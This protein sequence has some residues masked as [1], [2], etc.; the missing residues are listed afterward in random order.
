M[1]TTT[2]IV[3]IICSTIILIS[4]FI[5]IVW[6]LRYRPSKK[7][8]FL[9]EEIYRK[10]QEIN[11]KKQEIKQ[12]NEQLNTIRYELSGYDSETI[13]LDVGL[14]KPIF[15]FDTSEEYKSKIQELR[16][17]QNE[18]VKSGNACICQ[19]QWT[20]DG[21]RK[22]GLA[23]TKDQVN[24]AL[25]A[26]NGECDGLVSKV[27]SR[28]ITQ[29]RSRI[30]RSFEYI[31]KLNVRNA[32]SIQPKYLSL[33]IQELMATYEYAIKK[34]E[35]RA[36]QA[37]IKEEMREEIRAQR[38]LEKAKLDAE[39]AQK[40]AE[41]ELEHARKLLA[42]DQTNIELQTKLAELERKYQEAVEKSQRAMSQAQLTRSGHVYVIS[43]IGSFGENIFKIGMT[44]RL[45]PLDRIREL[46]DA[47]VPFSFDVHALI[48]SE[49]APTLE[50]E[51]H[52]VFAEYQLNRVNPRKEFFRVPLERI[53][54]EVRKRNAK[55]EFTMLAEATEYY[56]SLALEKEHQYIDVINDENEDLS[57]E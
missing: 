57:E 1:S 37:R 31:N 8:H 32:I 52:H 17:K 47:S 42:K 34:E 25:R 38:E 16:T 50:N 2:D 13:L 44:R 5:F 36:E 22:K 21:S 51:L 48:Y 3:L 29:L 18:L 55:I 33:K 43:N 20:V 53:A 15:S 40:E 6:F 54:E 35:E 26:F 28:N 9:Q 10:E 30:E 12:I 24:L 19:N 14:Y 27:N 39:K 45:E 41:R 46:G 23:M 11:L 56:Q 7:N 49:N 4:P